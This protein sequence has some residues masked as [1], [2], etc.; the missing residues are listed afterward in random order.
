MKSIIFQKTPL[1]FE[2]LVKDNSSQ[3]SKIENYG[4]ILVMTFQDDQ[5]GDDFIALM[6]DRQKGTVAYFVTA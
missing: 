5:A 3:I 1:N 6:S 2:E 4:E